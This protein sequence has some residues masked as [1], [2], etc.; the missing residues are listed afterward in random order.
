[1]FGDWVYEATPN[2]PTLLDIWGSA[3]D[4]ICAVGHGVALHYDGGGWLEHDLPSGLPGTVFLSIWGRRGDEIWT[5]GTGGTIIHWNGN[6]WQPQATPA[7][8]T[9]FAVGGNADTVWAVGG[10]GAIWRLESR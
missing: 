6:S 7:N 2:I 10:D 1:M 4:D 8:N 9:L 5:V 3:A